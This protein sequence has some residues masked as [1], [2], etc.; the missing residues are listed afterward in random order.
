MRARTRAK[1]QG[2]TA[3][4]SSVLGDVSQNFLMLSLYFSVVAL[5]SFWM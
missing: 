4:P 3:T 5:S 1:E 2:L